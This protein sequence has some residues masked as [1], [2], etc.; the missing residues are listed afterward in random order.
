M[1]QSLWISLGIFGELIMTLQQLSEKYYAE[2]ESQGKEIDKEVILKMLKKSSKIFN[3]KNIINIYVDNVYLDMDFMLVLIDYTFFYDQ[4]DIIYKKSDM[5]PFIYYSLM[6][7][8]FIVD[9]IVELEKALKR[10]GFDDSI[11]FMLKLNRHLPKET[12][13]WLKLIK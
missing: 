11:Y 6:T 3:I 12:K 9:E 13:L 2:F 1:S 8:P 7:R 10:D 5:M 4:K